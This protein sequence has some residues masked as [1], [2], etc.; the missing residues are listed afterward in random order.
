MLTET[1]RLQVM[2]QQQRG[3]QCSA[4]VHAVLVLN[5]NQVKQSN[6]ERVDKQTKPTHAETAE[7]AHA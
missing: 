1:T 3:A 6:D 5:P 2:L 4:A 7:H